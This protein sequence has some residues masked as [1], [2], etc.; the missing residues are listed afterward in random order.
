MGSV[1]EQKC[2]VIKKCILCV[3]KKYNPLINRNAVDVVI[4]KLFEKKREK[5][6]ERERLA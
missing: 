6:R 2:A 3:I 1:C 4:S 5:W